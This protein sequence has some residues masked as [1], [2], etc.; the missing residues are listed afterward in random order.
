MRAVVPFRTRPGLRRPSIELPFPYLPLH[1]P[2][3]TGRAIEHQR[4]NGRTGADEGTCGTEDLTLTVTWYSRIWID[5]ERTGVRFPG[6][7]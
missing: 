3:V 4:N 1:G 6:R 2:S 7:V 5:T